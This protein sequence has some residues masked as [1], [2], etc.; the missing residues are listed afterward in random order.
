VLRFTYRQVAEGPHR[1]AAI[2]A[3]KLATRA[4]I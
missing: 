2:V 3:A 4:A 1:A